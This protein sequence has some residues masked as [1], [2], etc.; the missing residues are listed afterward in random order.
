VFQTSCHLRCAQEQA[1]LGCTFAILSVNSLRGPAL[2]SLERRSWTVG[3][4]GNPRLDFG[5]RT[6]DTTLAAEQL[7][8][9]S[10]CNDSGR[11]WS[12]FYI[13]TF[14]FTRYRPL[15]FRHVCLLVNFNVE[16][17]LRAS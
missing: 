1:A 7:N 6:F 8:L 5:S 17:D 3:W 10:V 14:D 15:Y 9:V 2:G 11:R 4:A 13:V 12:N 16:S